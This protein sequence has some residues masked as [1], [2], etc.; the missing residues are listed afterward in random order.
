[1]NLGYG[2]T[3]ARIHADIHAGIARQ[4]IPNASPWGIAK[5]SFGRIIGV[6]RSDCDHCA[7]I[8]ISHCGCLILPVF[9]T[10]L[11]DA[12][13]IDPYIAYA[14]SLTNLNSVLES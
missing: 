14:K 9:I 13:T 12:K 4:R 11:D 1:M 5:A 8:N 10:V 7:F 2:E 3:L 6:G